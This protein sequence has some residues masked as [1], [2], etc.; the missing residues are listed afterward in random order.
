VLLELLLLS[1]LVDD[2]DDI[3]DFEVSIRDDS[4]SLVCGTLHHI[5]RGLIRL[6]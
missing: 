1:V 2:T 6:P 5:K 3:D 4:G